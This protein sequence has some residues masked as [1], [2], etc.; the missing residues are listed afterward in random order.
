[1]LKEYI[2][3]DYTINYGIASD[4]SAAEITNIIDK[5]KLAMQKMNTVITVDIIKINIDMYVKDILS[6]RYHI[7]SVYKESKLVAAIVYNIGSSMTYNG[8]IPCF[9]SS[10]IWVSDDTSA[11]DVFMNLK[12]FLH[13]INIYCVKVTDARK[14]FTDA[15]DITALQEGTT[16]NELNTSDVMIYFDKNDENIVNF[17]VRR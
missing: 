10:T 7:L 3:K 8:P 11:Q 4:Y 15:F 13:S 14:G 5:L 16:I 2:E 12:N 17:I 9:M 6:N 1:M